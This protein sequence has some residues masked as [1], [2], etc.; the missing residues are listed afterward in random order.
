[1]LVCVECLE[2]PNMRGLNLMTQLLGGL[3]TGQE[4]QNLLK[5]S[6]FKNI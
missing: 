5:Y 1:M 2:L 3:V 6:A 4:L